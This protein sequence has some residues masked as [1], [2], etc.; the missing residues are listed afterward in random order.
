MQG[1]GASA[2]SVVE[3]WKVRKRKRNGGEERA[4][5]AEDEKGMVSVA[6]RA[7]GVD[8]AE[9]PCSALILYF[10]HSLCLLFYPFLIFFHLSF[11]SM[12]IPVTV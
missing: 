9:W 12:K 8:A 2:A 4:A 5:G 6:Q 7:R 10:H 3:G 1:R 11:F